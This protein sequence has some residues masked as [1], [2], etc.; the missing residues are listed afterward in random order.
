MKNENVMRHLP[1]WLSLLFLIGGLTC[2]GV[3]ASIGAE[4]DA[5]GVL[6]EPF[7]LIPIGWLLFFASLV[8]AG[9][10][11]AGRAVRYLGRNRR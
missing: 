10:Y 4:I 9:L 2:W 7:A 8:A 1:L 5:Q 11:G 6:R 3:Y